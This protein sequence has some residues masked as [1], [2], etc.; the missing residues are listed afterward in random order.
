[1]LSCT[2]DLAVQHYERAVRNA[3]VLSFLDGC[4]RGGLHASSIDS[5]AMDRLDSYEQRESASDLTL[6][7]IV[8]VFPVAWQ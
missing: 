1:M 2:N 3:N 6:G 5:P 8:N 7:C 4:L